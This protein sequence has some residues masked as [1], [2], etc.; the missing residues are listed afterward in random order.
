MDELLLKAKTDWAGRKYVEFTVQDLINK[1]ESV[2]KVL[3]SGMIISGKGQH[4]E[5]KFDI[6][7]K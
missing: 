1:S 5:I 4:F 2:K 7:L 6:D 3:G